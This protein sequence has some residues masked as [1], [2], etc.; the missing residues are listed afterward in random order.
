MDGQ[1][2]R[3]VIQFPDQ[4]EFVFDH[5]ADPPGN[6]LRVALPGRFP[7]QLLQPLLAGIAFG[8]LFVRVFVTEFFQAEA[9]LLRELDA[10]RHGLLVALVQPQHVL[11]RA[12]M[13]LGIG[14]KP[15]T[16]AIDSHAL[17]HTDQNVGDRLALRRM[18]PRIGHGHHRDG[19]LLGPFL[20]PLEAHRVAAVEQQRRGQRHPVSAGVGQARQTGY[21]P[22]GAGRD[23]QQ[24]LPPGMRAEFRQAEFALTLCGPP[25]SECEQAAQAAPCGAVARIAN[26]FR[27]VTG[28]KARARKEADTGLARRDMAPH[29]AGNA[30]A[31]GQPDGRQPQF[32]GPVD[33]F[34]RVRGAAQKGE[35]ACRR[36][37]GV[38]LC[39][40]VRSLWKGFQAARA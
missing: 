28:L 17:A 22:Q 13:P 34:R 9:A 35:V 32:C 26:D 31:I 30:V 19:P 3:C 29:H 10:A 1:E 14:L 15:E 5:L 2:V 16:R 18:H 8:G 38:G 39:H 33:H 20:Q 36:Q 24:H 6:A 11:R 12:Q 21:L 37:F 27:S 7:G 25:L 23:D 4:L 40:S